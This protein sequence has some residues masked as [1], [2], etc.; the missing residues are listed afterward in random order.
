[1]TELRTGLVGAGVISHAHLPALLALSREV[2]VFSEVGAPELVAAHGGGTVVDSFAELLDRVDV[3]DV[4]TPTSTHAALVEQALRAGKDVICEKPLART[5]ADAQHLVDLATGLGRTLYPAQVVRFFPEYAALQRAVAAGDLGDLAVLRFWRSGAF[6][7]RSPWF[8]DVELSGGIVLDQMVH[9]LDIARWLAGEVATVSAV[10]RSAGTSQAP[11]QAA[12]VLLTHTSGAISQV[13]GTWGPE[14]LAF[15]TGFSVSGT[16]GTLAHDSAAERVFSTDLPPTG[17][18]GGLIPDVDPAES[19]YWT[20][21]AEF[22]A[23]FAGGPAP[24]VTAADGAAAVR[25]GNAALESLRTGQPVHLT[26]VGAR[27]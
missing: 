23:S 16:R 9:D 7:T 12:H 14:H 5:D 22:L 24:R 27:A 2:V 3:V 19:P 10:G 21:I 6:P 13:S 20:E 8:A 15:T 26:P 11:V 1:V 17:G 18:A 25:I 4:A